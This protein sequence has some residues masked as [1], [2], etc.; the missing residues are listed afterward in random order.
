LGILFSAILAI[1]INSV[2]KSDISD[3]S[4][5]SLFQIAQ[6]E[7]ELTGHFSDGYCTCKNGVCQD[8]NWI[9]FRKTCGTGDS[10]LICGTHSG[11]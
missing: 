4:M 11:C 9:G 10:D 5:N 2:S 6:S 1:N 3:L 7:E 8:G